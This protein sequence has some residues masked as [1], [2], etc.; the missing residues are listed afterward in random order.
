[1]VRQL[2]SATEHDMT[3]GEPVSIRG[4]TWSTNV[5]P[6]VGPAS[7]VPSRHQRVLNALL[8]VSRPGSGRCPGHASPLLA[9]PDRANDD[10]ERHAEDDEVG[11]HLPGD[12]KA[13]RL[14]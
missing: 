3:V 4:R 1:M 11:E 8:I 6:T 5:S 14:G 9:A 2:K 7:S 10:L 12:H 13:R